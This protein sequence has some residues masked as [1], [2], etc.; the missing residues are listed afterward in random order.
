MQNNTENIVNGKE[1]NK[2]FLEAIKRRRTKLFEDAKPFAESSNAADVVEQIDDE[3]F[4]KKEDKEEYDI[5]M[6]LMSYLDFEK[7]PAENT[8]EFRGLEYKSGNNSYRTTIY[9]S[10]ENALKVSKLANDYE[11]KLRRNNS[12]ADDMKMSIKF[13]VELLLLKYKGTNMPGLDFEAPEPK[14]AAQTRKE[15]EKSLDTYYEGHGVTKEFD[16]DAS[17]RTAYPHEKVNYRVN[18]PEMTNVTQNGYYEETVRDL[19]TQTFDLDH[20]EPGLEPDQEEPIVGTDR[21]LGRRIGDAYLNMKA[22]FQSPTL[23]SKLLKGLVIAGLGI[24]AVACLKANPIITVMLAAGV[25][26]GLLGIKYVLPPVQKGYNA[27][28]KKIKEWLFGPE[29]TNDPQGGNNDGDTEEPETMTPEQLTARTEEIQREI[30]AIDADIARLT[31]E[32][33]N[34]PEGSPERAAKEAEIAAKNREKRAKLAEVSALLHNY[35]AEHS[36][37]G[38]GR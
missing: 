10:K 38:L 15:Y 32:M 12:N 22:L 4:V 28:K 16:E 19:T 1:S 21:P 23:K 17:F 7:E 33:N 26:G 14:T 20:D 24:G 37:G 34:L 25:G 3:N 36:R 29:L 30:Q 2:R 11:D 13:P 6:T 35:D 31:E 9:L 18:P 27:I 5:L 8:Y